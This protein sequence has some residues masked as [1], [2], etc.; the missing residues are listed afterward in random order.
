MVKLLLNGS[1]CSAAHLGSGL[2]L[3]AQHCTVMGVKGVKTDRGTDVDAETLWASPAYDVAL[4]TTHAP[5]PA[6]A[7]LLSCRLVR[8]GEPVIVSGNPQMPEFIETRGTVLSGMHTMAFRLASASW[9]GARGG[10]ALPA[11]SC[12]LARPPPDHGGGRYLFPSDQ[13]R[14]HAPACA[15]DR[16]LSGSPTPTT[17]RSKAGLKAHRSIP[18]DSSRAHTSFR[19]MRWISWPKPS[20]VTTC[21]SPKSRT[22]ISACTPCAFDWSKRKALPKHVYRVTRSAIVDAISSRR[23]KS[24]GRA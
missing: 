8:K 5:L 22:W 14:Y 20:R 21:S 11:D 24:P 10:A 15:S 4:V 18:V 7:A 9:L 19:G 13:H 12:R 23:I 16:F 6:A 2:I 3:T 17:I 1:H